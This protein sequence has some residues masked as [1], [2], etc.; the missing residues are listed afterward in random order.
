MKR[1][2]EHAERDGD[3]WPVPNASHSEECVSPPYPDLGLTKLTSLE[4]NSDLF[5]DSAIMPL[6]LDDSELGIMMSDV[7]G[8]APD[9]I[10]LGDMA[11]LVNSRPNTATGGV[12]SLMVE[13]EWKSKQTASRQIQV[14]HEH[15][16][17]MLCCV[18]ACSRHDDI[19]SRH[20]CKV[21]NVLCWT[22][23]A[24]CFWRVLSL[25]AVILSR[26]EFI[27]G[28]ICCCQVAV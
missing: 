4:G 27:T 3:E 22:V 2:P 14:K 21:K 15:A 10:Q 17:V 8:L 26:T 6:E 19:V 1:E 25:F 13:S 11:D 28:S 9:D 18:C 16:V 5:P 23:M 12:P 20:C 24:L 7:C